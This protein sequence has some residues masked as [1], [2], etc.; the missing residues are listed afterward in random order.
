MVP[1]FSCEPDFGLHATV[2]G[3]VPPLNVGLANLTAVFPLFPLSV[4]GA[5]VGH[6]RLSGVARW[7]VAD[8]TTTFDVQ[9]AFCCRASTALQVND[10]LPTGKREPD[11]GEHVVVI[12]VTSPVTL[13]VNVT[14]T[15]FPSNE[16]NRGLGH[17][18]ARGS[19]VGC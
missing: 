7:A 14:D 10:A 11:V 9:E 17:Q 6:V 8:V 15:A 5:I 4:T 12:G 1:T 18:M 2:T 16:V 19:F 3:A 13:G